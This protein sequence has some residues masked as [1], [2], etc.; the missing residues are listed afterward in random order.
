MSTTFETMPT[1][2]FQG[3]LDIDAGPEVSLEDQMRNMDAEQLV[4]DQQE[5]IELLSD[6]ESV[7]HIRARILEE[8]GIMGV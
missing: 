4:A 6:L 3:A 7:I 1:E 5:A 2:L 8:K